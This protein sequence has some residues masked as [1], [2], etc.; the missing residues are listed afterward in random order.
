[1]L[2]VEN[3]SQRKQILDRDQELKEVKAE[4]EYQR[5][6]L[7]V[8]EM[9]LQE[10]QRELEFWQE[11]FTS[12]VQLETEQLREARAEINSQSE[13]LEGLAAE[14][15]IKE[16]QIKDTKAV[17][18]IREED[19][20]GSIENLRIK[21]QQLQDVNEAL[22]YDLAESQVELSQVIKALQLAHNSTTRRRSETS[23]FKRE[24]LK[25]EYPTSQAGLGSKRA[26]LED[27]TTTREEGA[28]DL[29]D[30]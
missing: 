26:R 12:A 4:N 9:Q 14:L 20:N 3:E 15:R 19:A 24:R 23:R 16:K 13:R 7:D 22:E 30:A 6:Q 2:K 5:K 29:T 10:V 11:E 17:I 27:V 18:E 8:K 25:E 28:I 21:V 1:M